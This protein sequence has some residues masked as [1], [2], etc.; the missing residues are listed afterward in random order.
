METEVREQIIN[1]LAGEITLADLEAWLVASTWEVEVGAADGDLAYSA[2]L[3][4]AERARQHRS[5]DDVERELRR[6]LSTAH[7]GPRVPIATTSGA[8]TERVIQWTQPQIVGA[9]RRSAAA[10]G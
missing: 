10:R 8:I 4:L 6:L 3:L 7:L 1:H 9:G 2:Q 5:D